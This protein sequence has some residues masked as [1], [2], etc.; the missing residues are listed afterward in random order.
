M[1]QQAPQQI[2]NSTVGPNIPD[3]PPAVNKSK[4]PSKLIV[5][6]VVLFFIGLAALT[7]FVIRNEDSQSSSKP[8]SSG[9]P[10]KPATS[11]VVD[12]TAREIEETLQKADNV[13]DINSADLSDSSLG[14]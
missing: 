3:A 5:A 13:N 10:A 4:K 12:E 14:L 2:Y 1:V 7:I 6:L 8:A 11:G 9:S